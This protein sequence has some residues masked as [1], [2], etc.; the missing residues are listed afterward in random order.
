MARAKIITST[1][2]KIM[3]EGTTAEIKEI[4]SAVKQ[5]EISSQK[6]IVT[7]ERGKGQKK[8]TATDMILSFRESG[9]FNKPKNLLDIKRALEEQGMIYPLTTLSP[10][11][12]KLVRKRLI[13]R[14]KLDKKWCYVKR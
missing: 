7:K 13:G 3:I 9:Y 6:K 4:I 8:D 11:L 10:I 5:S 1:G 12:L 2:S 14:I